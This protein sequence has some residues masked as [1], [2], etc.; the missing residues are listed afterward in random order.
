M[1]LSISKTIYLSGHAPTADA[2]DPVLQGPAPGP[3]QQR[4]R[5]RTQPSQ[6]ETNSV[7]RIRKLTVYFLWIIISGE[8]G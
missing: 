2:P 3:L 8:G 5:L 1:C 7:V 6:V 4:S